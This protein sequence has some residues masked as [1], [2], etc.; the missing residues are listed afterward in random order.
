M[1]KLFQPLKVGP[2][3]LSHRIILP[4][5]TRIRANAA[6]VPQ[7]SAIEYYTQ[8][9]STPGTLLITEGTYISPETG[10]MPFVPGIYNQE[11]IDAWK[12]VTASVHEK[13]CYIYLQLWTLG[14]AA[15]PQVLEG[16]LGVGTKVKA[17]SAIAYEGGVVPEELTEEEIWKCIKDHRQAA[18]NAIEADFDG[19]EVHG[20]CGYLPD[21]FL[22]DVSN[23]RTDGWGGS[24]EKRARF[25]LEVAKAIADAVGA[26]RTGFRMSPLGTFQGMRMEEGKFQAQFSYFT[27]EL[28]KLN[29]AYIHLVTARTDGAPEDMDPEKMKFM[30]DT[31]GKTSPVFLAGGFN[32]EMAYRIVDEEL[33]DR[34]VAVAFGRYFTSNPD[35]V[36]RVKEKISLAPYE[37]SIFFSNDQ[38]VG[39]TDYPF[40]KEFEAQKS[41]LKA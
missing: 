10:G 23:Q 24:V 9:A 32:P 39:Y 25:G 28:K 20:A 41:G 27:Q 29:L 3:T 40:S 6:H 30:L 33:K 34:E 38:V 8:R 18:L 4:P 36:F 21:Q 12:P 2:I 37:R 11:Q 15:N 26:E 16:E 19:V 5:M 1:S 7:P 35:L 31:W 17:P 14:R 13:G 22:Q